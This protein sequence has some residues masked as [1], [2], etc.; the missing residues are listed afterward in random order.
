MAT[1]TCKPFSVV[2]VPFPYVERTTTKRRPALVV[3]R[4]IE[5]PLH[6]LLWVLMITS[7]SNRRWDGDIP[8]G[9]LQ[10]AGLHHPSVIRTAKIATVETDRTIVIGTITDQTIKHVQAVLAGNLAL[11]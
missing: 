4:E 6:S 1:P 2:A 3:T 9:E 10:L 5:Q 7:A 8:I 11:H